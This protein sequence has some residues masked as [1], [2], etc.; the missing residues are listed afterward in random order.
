MLEN[1]STEGFYQIF[2]Q[3]TDFVTQ[4]ESSYAGYTFPTF[5]GFT[6]TDCFPSA[7]SLKDSTLGDELLRADFTDG[8]S[9]GKGMFATSVMDFGS[10][11]ISDGT[12]SGYQLHQ[13]GQQR[14][15]GAGHA[16]QPEFQPD[17]GRHH[18]LLGE[19]Q[20]KPGYHDSEAERCHP[21][22]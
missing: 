5:N 18:V 21:R 15:R 16:D 22:L 2:S 7:S 10:F 14:S 17:D 9:V 11:T 6:V 20:L 13:S 12:V 1:P 4:V 19:P 8:S 3:H